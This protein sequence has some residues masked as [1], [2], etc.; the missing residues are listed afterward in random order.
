ML[1]T[2]SKIAASPPVYEIYLDCTQCIVPQ[3]KWVKL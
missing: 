2:E 3:I 1:R